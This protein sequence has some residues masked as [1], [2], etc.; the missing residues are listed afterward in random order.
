MRVLFAFGGKQK[1]GAERAITNIANYMIK[2][3]EIHFL[4]L[5]KI[6]NF[7]EINSNIKYHLMETED[8]YSSN[9]LVRNIRRVKKIKQIINNVNPDI[10]ISFAREQSYRILLLN[11]FNKR[12]IIVSVR[13]DPKHEYTSIFEKIV[14]RILY[15]RVNGFVFQTEEA[16]DFFGKKIGDKSVIIPNPINEK[17]LVEKQ[18]LKKEKNIVSV[19][20]LVEQKNH[21][22]LIEAISKIA[23][24]FKDYKVIIYGSGE[25]KEQLQNKINSLK[26]QKQIILAGEV[27]DVRENI[28]D[29]TLFVLPSIYEG[30]PN[31]LIEAMAIGLP[32]ISTN[33]PCGGPRFLIENNINGILVPINDVNRMANEMERLLKDEK[34]RYNLGENAKKIK[35]LLNSEKINNMWLDF[36]K[37]IVGDTSEQKN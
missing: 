12:K 22:L 34:L 5:K 4:G 31:S 23:K 28:E 20:R 8:D 14:M 35:K 18:I 33:C 29:A 15:R 24:K 11:Y 21:V 13:N 9:F 32:C 27:I 19:G 3:N 25:L 37:K 10:I 30:M 7:Y 1:G 16:R 36:I 6:D 26:L 17:Y 2:N